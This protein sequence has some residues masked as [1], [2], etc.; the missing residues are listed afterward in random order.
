MNET[1]HKR[2]NIVRFHFY[3]VTGI[4][5]FI[6]TESRIEVTRGWGWGG[7]MGSYCL[8]GTKYLFE[9]IKKFWNG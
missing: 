9:M 2:T 7:R 5:N 4:G 1:R 8:M 6:E 3:E